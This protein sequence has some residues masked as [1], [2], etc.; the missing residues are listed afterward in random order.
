MPV[1]MIIR[2]LLNS[3]ETSLLGNPNFSYL[4]GKNIKQISKLHSDVLIRMAFS[5]TFK[6]ICIFTS[7]YIHT[8]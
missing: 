3:I 6:Y 8:I 2:G 7:K 4:S 5:F 1:I